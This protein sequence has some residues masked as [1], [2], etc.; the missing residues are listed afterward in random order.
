M[1]VLA[2]LHEASEHV[3]RPC[4]GDPLNARQIA[5]AVNARGLLRATP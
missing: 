2:I 5:Q 1:N 4:R 3:L